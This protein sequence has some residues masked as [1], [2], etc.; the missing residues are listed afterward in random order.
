MNA[1]PLQTASQFSLA[2]GALGIVYGDIG[3]SPL[4]AMRESIDGM[5]IGLPVIL[6]ILSLIFWS[7]IAIISI[8]YL[9]LVFR[10]DNDGEGGML[11]LLAL[12][13]RSSGQSLLPFLFIIGIFGAGLMLG[14]GMLTP[15]ISIVSAVEGLHVVFPSLG[16]FVVPISCVILVG[17]FSVQH[18]GT[19]KIGFIFGPVILIWFVTIGIL[20]V[21]NIIGNPVVLQA[22]NPW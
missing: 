17:L 12:L 13:K 22:I 4:Y 15:A 10:A 5:S 18:Y 7:L 19:A 3:T 11:A 20:G 8:K 21:H 14:D 16:F 1:K 2:I 6:G 9:W